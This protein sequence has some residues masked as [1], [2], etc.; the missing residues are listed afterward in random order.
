MEK[1]LKDLLATA[2]FGIAVLDSELRYV[3]INHQLASSNGLSIE[4]HIGRMPHDVLPG[5]GP[6]LEEI[7]HEVMASGIAEC[8]FEASAEIPPDSGCITHWN[9]SYHPWTDK[10]GQCVG[11]IAMVE[12][13]TLKKQA[14]Q[15]IRNSNE[16]M[17]RVLD[18]LFTFVGVLSADGRLLDANRA[19]LE[20]GGLELAEVQGKYFWDCYW[21]SHD[22]AVQQQLQQAIQQCSQG[23]TVRY[24]VLV[25]MKNDSRMVIDF[26]LRPLRDDD[27]HVRTLIASGID[28]TARKQN[29]QALAVSETYFRRVVE[30]T[31]DGLMIVNRQGKILLINHRMEELFGYERAEMVGASMDILLPPAF[32]QRHADYMLGYF[33]QPSARSM[34]NRKPLFAQ[35]KDGS[36]FSCEIGLNP[37]IVGEEQLT[38]ACITDVSERYQAKMLLEKALEEKTVLLGEVHHRVKNNLQV[39][40]S[41]LS[42]QA[43]TATPEAYSAL[44]D[45]QNHVRSMA[46]IHQLLYERNDFSRIPMSVYIKRLIHLLGDVCSGYGSYIS[47][48]FEHQG[49][50]AFLELQNSIPFG[51]MM[52]EIVVNACKHAFLPGS[53]G[54]VTITLTV[55]DEVKVEICDNGKGVPAGVELGTASSLGFQLLPMLAEQLKCSLQLESAANHGSCFTLNIP[56]LSR[57]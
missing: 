44:L 6:G 47:I 40:S 12:D 22:V 15:A 16:R 42:L 52:N 28:V 38:L 41:L 43:R 19:P 2:P 18:A 21:W 3:H 46:L 36:Q 45:S 51:L 10:Q 1:L 13:V 29:E 50:E 17:R 49:P 11:I 35:R 57:G 37:L 33:R 20:Q 14:E 27:G 56:D 24:D 9:A 26:M 39:I 4:Q 25:R 5:A 32:R 23:E 30:S 53:T 7:M 8:N 55:G 31:P 54:T 34:A 48:R